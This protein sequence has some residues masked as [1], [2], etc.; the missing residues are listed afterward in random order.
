MTP[1][2]YVQKRRCYECEY[3]AHFGRIE[4]WLDTEGMRLKRRTFEPLMLEEDQRAEYESATRE[5]MTELAA[6]EQALWQTP[7]ASERE[8]D[9]L[10]EIAAA[11]GPIEHKAASDFGQAERYI[12]EGVFSEAI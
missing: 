9:L 4:Q 11:A 12:N 3:T 6:R 5:A 10:A 8:E 2:Y 7:L 1:F